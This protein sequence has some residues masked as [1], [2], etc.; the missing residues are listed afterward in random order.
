MYRFFVL[1]GNI[2]EAAGEIRIC[3]ED[4]SHIKNVLRMR[5]GEN[6]ILCTGHEDDPVDYICRIESFPEGQ[7]LTRIIEKK[8]SQAELPSKL[9]LFQGLPK[10]DKLES[11]IQKSVELG[12][13]EIIPTVMQRSVVKLDDRKGARK[14]ERWNAISQSAAKQSKRG[15][16]PHVEKPLSFKESLAYAGRLDHVL[17]PYEDAR[18][19]AHTRE[20]LRSVQKGESAGIFIGPE[21]GFSDSEIEDLQEIGAEIITLGHRILRTE[22]AGIAVLSM[23]MMNL[24][25]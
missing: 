11:V 19:M 17:V 6:V 4:V 25:N 15:I 10:A 8:A 2:D 13:Y 22:T 24:E 20:V 21:G 23:L 12:V 1:P 18:G 3:G 14:A 5:P 16:I 9:Y 7:V